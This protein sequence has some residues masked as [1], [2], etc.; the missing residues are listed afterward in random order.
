MTSE[1]PPIPNGIRATTEAIASGSTW[2]AETTRAHGP[3]PLSGVV[4]SEDK[5]QL[6]IK[7]R[8]GA[9]RASQVCSDARSRL[10]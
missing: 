8:L 10:A 6:R 2:G 9:A 5:V 4:D 1:T 3:R 7:V